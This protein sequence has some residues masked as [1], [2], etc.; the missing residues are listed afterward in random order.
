MTGFLHER[1]Y[2]RRALFKGGGALVV[3]FSALG[4]LAGKAVAADS[5][6]AS[7]PIDGY[8]IDSWIAIHADNTA[9]IKSGGIRQGTGS[10]TGLLM[11]AGEELNMAMS[12]LQF[13]M[14]DTNITPNSGKHSASNT[15]KN[16][17][18]AVRAASAA[19]AQ[20]LLGLA[21]TNLGVPVGS[22]TVAKGVVSGGGKS[23]TYGALLGGKFFNVQMPASFNMNPPTPDGGFSG[24][25]QAGQAPTKSPSQ[26]TLV[27]TSPPRIDIP[28]IVTGA[29]VYIQNIRVPGMLHGRVVRPTGQSVFGFGAPIV[30]LDESSISHIPNVKIVRQGNFLGVVAPHEFDAIQAA[31]QL[32]VNWGTPP[33]A[34]PGNGNEFEGL[35]ALD[36]AG[37]T[38]MTA[39]DLGGVATN[40]GNVDTALASAAHVFSAS[41]GWPTNVHTPIGPQCAIA[42]V[43]PQGARIYSGT[44]GAYQTRQVVAPALGLPEN[45]VRVTAAAM[46]GCFGDGCQY[47]DVAIAA[48][49]MSQSVGAPVRVQ[50]MRPTEIAWGNVSPPSLMDVRAG[51]DAH[52][53]LV[54]FDFTHFYPQY[55]TDTY[56]TNVELAGTPMPAVTSSLSGQYW[57]GPMYNIPNNRYLVKSIPLLNNWFK[58]YWM[59]GGSA[60]HTTFAGEQVMDELAHSV[61]MDPVAF[62]IQ[63]VVNGNDITQGQAKDQ[64]LAVM[65]EVTKAANWQATVSASNLS[66]A[67]VVTGRGVAWSNVDSPKTYAQTAAVADIEVNKK[68]GKITVKHVYQAVSTGLAVYPGG[69]ENQIV[70]GVTQITSRLLSEQYRYTQTNVTSTDFVTYPLLRFKDAPKV[71][72]MVIQWSTNPTGGVGEPMAMAAAAAVANAFY[73]ATGVRMTTAPFTPARVRAALKAATA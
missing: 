27:G 28:D 23:V 2:S 22:L 14:A 29:I 69:I 60:P 38:V 24:G 55:K 46:G 18:P 11:I 50:L 43:T 65:N 52:G 40:R 25:L 32:K 64:L 5:P 53:N 6:F 66:E 51:V 67:N 70:G 72:P 9:T 16:A 68:T 37:K 48:G 54:A 58:V 49:L 19:A 26:Y 13:V 57:P 30:S 33:P 39:V 20:V 35:R 41:F 7:N 17:G 1:A 12:Q 59:R 34:L 62:R 47:F 56:Q 71:T 10:D 63:N 31:A 36:T 15:I 21:S 73:D 8:S 3:S 61:Q 4:G 42:D 45:V 44:Q